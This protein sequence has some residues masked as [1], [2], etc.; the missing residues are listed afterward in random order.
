MG[1]W[2]MD[3]GKRA[4]GNGTYCPFPIV[5]RILTLPE[6]SVEAS[7]EAHDEEGAEDI[8]YAPA[9]ADA[10]FELGGEGDGIDLGLSGRGCEEADAYHQDDDEHQQPALEDE[11]VCLPEPSRVLPEGTFHDSLSAVC[12][13]IREQ[14]DH[15]DDET[16]DESPFTSLRSNLL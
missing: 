1:N 6:V 11:P 3:N 16:T 7:A 8:P 12:E 4:M 13:H 9:L 5:H 14:T 15:A 10:L 2:K